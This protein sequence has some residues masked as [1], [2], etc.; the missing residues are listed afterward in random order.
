MWFYINPSPSFFLHDV[1]QEG[2]HL[3]SKGR[4]S[5]TTRIG[6]LTWRS[7]VIMSRNRKYFWS[8]FALYMLL[9]LSVGTIF[10][11]AGH[12]LSSVMVSTITLLRLNLLNVWYDDKTT[13]FQQ[14]RVSAIFVYVSFVILLSVSG[15]PAH[16][17]EI[18]V[19]VLVFTTSF[20]FVFFIVN[21]VILF[22]FNTET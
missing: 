15:V 22:F 5:N 3:K 19:K 6:V 18:K 8:R 21:R 10:N 7:L 1:L 11:N 2:P 13:L 4:A 14:V 20:L 12:S 9:A 16:I 17:D